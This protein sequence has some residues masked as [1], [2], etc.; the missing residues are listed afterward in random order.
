MSRR[1]VFKINKKLDFK[2]H[3]I[4]ISRIPSVNNMPAE[5]KEYYKKLKSALDVENQRKIFEKET[6][7]FYGKD[8]KK[9]RVLMV[10]QVQEMWD[11]M[12]KPYFEKMDKIHKNKFPLRKVNGILSTT[13]MVYGYNFD[14]L[15]PWFTCSYNSPIKAV[16]TTMH[17]MMHVYFHKYFFKKYKKKF[18]LTN[19]QIWTVK[20]SL[21]V[22]LNLE[23][24]GLRI[25]PDRGKL[26]HEKLRNRIKK[27]WV[28]YGD[29]DKVMEKICLCVKK[30]NFKGYFGT[31]AK[32]V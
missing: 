11:L 10:K 29:L 32:S 24:G 30:V 7:R 23:F 3:L 21:T 16:H 25:F 12:E 13:P 31:W 26:G 20:E 8:S 5:H 18:K 4:G 9:F 22:L 28:K 17:E 6:S 15:N 2:N 14:G 19:N 1:V 27:D